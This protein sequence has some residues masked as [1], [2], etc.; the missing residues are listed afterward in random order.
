MLN[1]FDKSF[2]VGPKTIGEGFPCFIIAEAGVSHFGDVK[3]AFQLVDA[4]VDA[5]AD[6]VKFQI[7]RTS[8]LISSKNKEWTDRMK[9][10]ELP[11]SDFKRIK[12]YSEE[13]GIIFFATAHDIDSLYELESLNPPVYKIGSG[14]VKNISFFRAVAKLGKPVIFSTGMYSEEDFVATLRVLQE[15]KCQKVA[16][17]HCVTSY[18]TSPKDVNLSRIKKIKKLFPGPV[19]YSDHCEFHDI[20]PASVLYGACLIEKHVTLEK[21]IPNAQDWKVSCDPV[22]LIEFI[23][24]VRR[25]EQAVGSMEFILGEEEKKSIAWAR[26]SAVASK[27][28]VAGSVLK[29]AD[30]CFKRPGTGISPDQIDKFYGKKVMVDIKADELL[31]DDMLEN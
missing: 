26:K 15:E 29:P 30:I 23:Q 31:A 28:L 14:E 10:K 11:L 18:P 6:A 16:V 13:K 22:E 24:R 8:A 17:M 27:D 25:L 21:N 2:S 1:G 20:A 9:P 12:E 5:G 19:G 4:A 3:K 7:F